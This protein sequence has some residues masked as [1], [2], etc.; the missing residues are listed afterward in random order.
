M[1]INAIDLD[2]AFEN[3][4]KGLVDKASWVLNME[5]VNSEQLGPSTYKMIDDYRKALQAAISWID[6]VEDALREQHINGWE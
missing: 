4:P 2:M 1:R 6:S 3:T 5:L